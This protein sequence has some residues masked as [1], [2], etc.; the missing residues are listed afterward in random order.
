MAARKVLAEFS[1]IVT[2]EEVTPLVAVLALEDLFGVDLN[3][4]RQG[5]LL[6]NLL[7]HL[8]KTNADHVEVVKTSILRE[9]VEIVVGAEEPCEHFT[10]S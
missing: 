4:T 9:F 7:G 3:P 1:A 2:E 5:D 6:R 10:P 8:S